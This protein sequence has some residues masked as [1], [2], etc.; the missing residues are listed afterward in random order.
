MRLSGYFNQRITL[1]N[2]NPHFGYAMTIQTDLSRR[3]VAQVD[4]PASDEGTAVIDPYDDAFSGSKQRD[5]Y[6]G[7]EREALVSGGELAV[8]KDLT[9]GGTPAVPLRPVMGSQAD[10]VPPVPGLRICPAGAKQQCK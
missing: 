8:A 2:L 1:Q 6:P 4:H 10:K 3:F 5:T 9:A 7:A